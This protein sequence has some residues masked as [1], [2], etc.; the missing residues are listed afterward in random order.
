MQ[1]VQNQGVDAA[2]TGEPFPYTREQISNPLLIYCLVQYD[3]QST[4]V[5]MWN[6]KK[7]TPVNLFSVCE[8]Q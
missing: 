1:V 7:A 8:Q 3:G 6:Y 4:A 5:K 2:D